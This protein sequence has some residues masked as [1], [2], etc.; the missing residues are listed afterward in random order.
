MADLIPLPDDARR[1]LERPGRYAVI[2]TLGADGTPH[3]AVIWYTVDEA[4]LLIN[5]RVGRRWPTDLL[6]DP[7]VSL[8]VDASD[9]PTGREAYVTVQ[10]RAVPVA[11]GDQ[12]MADIQLLARRYDQPTDLWTGQERISFR[13]D[14]TACHV[15]GEA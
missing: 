8:T 9:V 7:R 4:G 3:Q 12:A 14:V 2:A 6:R 5:S 13:L 15:Y 1:F 10:A 11:S